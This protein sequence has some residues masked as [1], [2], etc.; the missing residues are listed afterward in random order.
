MPANTE[1]K[2][3]HLVS[4]QKL[5]KQEDLVTSE[6]LPRNVSMQLFEL[7]KQIVQDEISPKT[8]HAACACASE[9]SKIL[10]IN[11]EMRRRGM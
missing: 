1:E 2:T 4:G 6:N 8:V 11:N 7:M 5:Q 3:Q 9:I 10:K